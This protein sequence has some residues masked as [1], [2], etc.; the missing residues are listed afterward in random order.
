V[1]QLHHVA[2]VLGVQIRGW[3]IGQQQPW[4]VGQ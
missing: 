4:L 2:A 3:L 1:Q